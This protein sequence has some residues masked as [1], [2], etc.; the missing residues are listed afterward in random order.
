MFVLFLPET[1]LRAL[2]LGESIF[3]F[4]SRK[5]AKVAKNFDVCFVLPE[6]PLRALRLG[7]SIFVIFFLSLRRRA[8]REF[9]CFV[10][11]PNTFAGFA[12]WREYI[13]FFLSQRRQGRQELR[14]L[15]CSY[16]EHLCVLCALAR[17]NIDGFFYIANFG[18][19]DKR[20]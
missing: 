14:C 12:P 18:F 7:E 19:T 13:C 8:R 16:P 1:P 6:T 2:R 4:F 3:V 11:T 20:S 10:L 5:G 9:Q 15:F 17:V